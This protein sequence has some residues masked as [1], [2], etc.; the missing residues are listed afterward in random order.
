MHNQD[1]SLRRRTAVD[2]GVQHS[3]NMSKLGHSFAV[4]AIFPS[5]AIDLG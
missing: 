1:V 4:A 3:K 5:D 2:T